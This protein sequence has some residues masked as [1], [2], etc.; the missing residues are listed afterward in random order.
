MWT[1]PTPPGVLLAL[2]QSGHIHIQA[3]VRFASEGI[4]HARHRSFCL[5]GRLLS[6]RN[7]YLLPC[8]MT[9]GASALCVALYCVALSVCLIALTVEIPTF[10]SITWKQC[11][12]R[13]ASLGFQILFQ[14]L[15]LSF[16]LRAPPDTTSAWDFQ[17]PHVWMIQLS[18]VFELY[19]RVC[20]LLALCVL[21]AD[22]PWLVS[23][24]AVLPVRYCT[25]TDQ[26]AVPL[27]RTSSY[28]SRPDD[29]HVDRPEL[30]PTPVVGRVHQLRDSFG[31]RRW[32][33]N[34][35]WHERVEEVVPACSTI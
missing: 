13:H 10:N 27:L 25:R 16:L 1:I 18:A 6:H 34:Y 2:G 7:S 14:V 26:V 20:S 19:S 17:L 12:A 30:P 22:R 15:W 9:T 5:I 29:I 32:C 33:C 24:C 3:Q 35:L 8:I 23:I 21:Q 4:P 11:L 31:H 28:A